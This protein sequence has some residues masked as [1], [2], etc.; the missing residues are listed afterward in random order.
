METPWTQMETPRPGQRHPWT[1]TETP[2]TR[3]RPLDPDGDSPN[4]DEDPLDLDGDPPGPGWIP[5]QTQIETTLDPDR[6]SPDPDEEPLDPDRDPQTLMEGIWDEGQRPPR[7][8]MGPGTQ[9]GSDIIQ[10]PPCEQNYWQTDVKTLPCP[11]LHLRAVNM[12]KES[13][14]APVAVFVVVPVHEIAG[15]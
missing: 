3:W 6:D 2:W 11:K 13:V 7:R 1:Q 5:L 15:G 8:N 9:T 10:R 14:L 12:S 4:P